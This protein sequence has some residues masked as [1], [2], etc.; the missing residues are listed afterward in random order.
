MAMSSC[1]TK[2]VQLPL[3]C[4]SCTTLQIEGLEWNAILGAT[5]SMCNACT[6]TTS[7]PLELQVYCNV[8]VPENHTRYGLPP[9]GPCPARGHVSSDGHHGADIGRHGRPKCARTGF[10]NS[11]S[12][13][14]YGGMRAFGTRRL[15]TH[16][17]CPMRVPTYIPG[18][19]GTSVRPLL[20]RQDYLGR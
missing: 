17:S 3:R 15:I 1:S 2:L 4:C 19:P 9:C 11:A 7:L 8:V 18:H 20:L 13:M 5:A 14:A 10:S 6:G 12:G 16:Q